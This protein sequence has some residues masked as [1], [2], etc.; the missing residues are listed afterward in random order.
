M[1]VATDVA[2]RG[3]D[4][5]RVA[6]VINFDLPRDIDS[7]V[8]RIGRTGRTGKSGLAYVL[9]NVKISGIAKP[10]SELMKEAHQEAQGWIDQV[11]CLVGL[12]VHR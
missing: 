7:Y 1:L 6:H 8:L 2:S 12:E 11:N 10:I 4:I 9:F 5:P 3:L